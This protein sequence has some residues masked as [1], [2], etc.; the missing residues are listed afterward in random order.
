M[1]NIKIIAISD[2]H[3]GVV[4][5]ALGEDNFVE[6]YSS[7]KYSLQMQALDNV[8]QYALDNDIDAVLIAGDLADSDSDYFE[9]YSCLEKFSES[10][11]KNGIMVFAVSGNHDGNLL[12]KLSLKED[13]FKILGQNGL[14]QQEIFNLRDNKQI[15]ISARS[16]TGNHQTESHLASYKPVNK[17][18]DIPA[19]GLLHCDLGSTNSEYAPSA[20]SEFDKTNEDIWICG[21]IHTSKYYDSNKKLLIPGSLQGLDPSESGLHGGYL[22]ECEGNIIKNVKMIPF[23]CAYYDEVSVTIK[24]ESLFEETITKGLQ[25]ISKKY[26]KE[27]SLNYILSLRLNVNVPYKLLK[28]FKKRV[29][30]MP[31]RYPINFGNIVVE[32]IT[33]KTDYLSDLETLSKRKDPLGILANYLRVLETKTPKEKYDEYIQKSSKSIFKNLNQSSLSL[34]SPISDDEDKIRESLLKGGEVLMSKF[35]EELGLSND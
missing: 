18:N 2:I 6:K 28:V 1:Q 10:L 34:L 25:E 32:K 9:T 3:F 8:S 11:K 21:H 16:Y 4:P 20:I 14:W 15:F 30:D 29:N 26:K 5:S 35:I 31:D 12:K 24:E 13:N 19:F 27:L 22:I 7:K 23:A 17:P 33:L